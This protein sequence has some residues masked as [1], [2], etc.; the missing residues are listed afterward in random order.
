MIALFLSLGFEKFRRHSSPAGTNHEIGYL[1]LFSTEGDESGKT[2]IIVRVSG[3]NRIR[4]DPTLLAG[5]VDIG[6]HFGA[7]AVRAVADRRMMYRDH[8]RF[9]LARFSSRFDRGQGFGQ[10]L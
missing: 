4:S 9:F 8:K 7:G 6:Q 1:Q 10:P 3:K 5:I 2:L